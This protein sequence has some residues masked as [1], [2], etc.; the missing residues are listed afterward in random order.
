LEVIAL[1][2]NVVVRVLTADDPPQVEAARR[3]MR[4]APLFLAKT[5]L[6]E[7]E[8]VLRYSYALDRQTIGD[9]LRKLI[10]LRRLEVEDLPAVIAALSWHAR[11]MDLA[12]ALHLASSKPAG[13]LVTFDRGLAATAEALG[14]MPRVELL[15]S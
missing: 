3:V 10:R 7:T 13:S 11:G 12:D 6:L 4:S 5:V 15:R 1:D 9:A 14:C 8:W 2:T